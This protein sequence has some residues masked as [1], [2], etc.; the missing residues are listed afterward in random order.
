MTKWLLLSVDA[1]P[2]MKAGNLANSPN[3]KASPNTGGCWA[4]SAM[5]GLLQKFRLIAQDLIA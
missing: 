4:F 2:E 1:R 3:T 5:A